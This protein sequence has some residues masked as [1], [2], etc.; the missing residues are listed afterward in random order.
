[1][2]RTLHKTQFASS[3]YSRFCMSLWWGVWRGLCSTSVLIDARRPSP[4]PLQ[5]CTLSKK[6]KKGSL[7]NKTPCS[8]REDFTG[9][10]ICPPSLAPATSIVHLQNLP[11]CR[12][13]RGRTLICSRPTTVI[14]NLH[15]RIN[16]AAEP[17][18]D[19]T[20]QRRK[21]GP[22]KCSVE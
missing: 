15:L 8:M 14:I 12:R 19:I 17:S 9:C 1:M 18:A 21:R 11:V 2:T 6:K 22:Q 13:T 7:Q 3:S 10:K 4:L 20:P 5:Y 16:P